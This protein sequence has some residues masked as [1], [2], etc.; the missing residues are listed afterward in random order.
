MCVE[1]P[2]QYRHQQTQSHTNEHRANEDFVQTWLFWTQHNPEVVEN[3]V[4]NLN[5]LEN[6]RNML[7]SRPDLGRKILGF[8]RQP[9]WFSRTQIENSGLGSV[10]YNISTDR[11][12]ACQVEAKKTIAQW[13][14]FSSQRSRRVRFEKTVKPWDGSPS[15]NGDKRAKGFPFRTEETVNEL[16]QRLNQIRR[17]TK[18]TDPVEWSIAKSSVRD[19]PAVR[20]ENARCMS[21]KEVQM[22]EV[23]EKYHSTRKRKR[24]R[25]TI[26]IPFDDA[27]LSQPENQII[28]K[29]FRNP[30]KRKRS[31][32]EK[33]EIT[34]LFKCMADAGFVKQQPSNERATKTEIPLIHTIRPT[35]IPLRE[36]NPNRDFPTDAQSNA[37]FGQKFKHE[38]QFE[39]RKIDSRQE[40][41][42][43]NPY[44]HHRKYE[45]YN[46]QIGGQQKRYHRDRKNNSPIYQYSH[47][48]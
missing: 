5:G 1:P 10:V 41:Y 31:D 44:N 3:F 19:T 29:T 4:E 40:N 45:G 12:H 32:V 33:N 27:P 8:L 6:V 2:R 37:P 36:S 39:S 34:I 46:H 47:G 25:E 15:E 22:G 48:Y 16:G 18:W 23:T 38:N 43:Y 13:K 21:V 26:E 17:K 7:S 11:K 9:C 24:V 30:K 28:Q 42:R 14:K 35:L 20:A